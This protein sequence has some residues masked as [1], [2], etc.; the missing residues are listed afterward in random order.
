MR[1]SHCHVQLHQLQRAHARDVFKLTRTK[2]LSRLPSISFFAKPGALM[3]SQ[4]SL[5][6]HMYIT[7][8]TWLPSVSLTVQ[9]VRGECRG[10]KLRTCWFSGP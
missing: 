9:S 2:A 3:Y 7:Y 4:E 5:I 8:I 10:V 6:H 1:L